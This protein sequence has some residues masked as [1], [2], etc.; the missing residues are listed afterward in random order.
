MIKIKYPNRLKINGRASS[1]TNAFYN[2]ILPVIK[3]TDEEENKLKTISDYNFSKGW[4]C[5]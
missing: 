5:I 4:Q 2:G 1:L 3:H